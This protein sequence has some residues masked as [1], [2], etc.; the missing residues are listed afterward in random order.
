MNNSDTDSLIE[1]LRKDREAGKPASGDTGHWKAPVQGSKKEREA[2]L[3][4]LLG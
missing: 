4:K 2:I 1:Q 3:A